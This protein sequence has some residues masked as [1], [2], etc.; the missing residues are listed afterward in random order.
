MSLDIGDVAGVLAGY[1]AGTITYDAAKA[2]LREFGT[3][4]DDID[5]LLAG[6]AAIGVGAAVG[7]L[8][9]DVFDGIFGGD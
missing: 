5:P 4:D 9:D 3:G 1:K 6:V 2:M 8:V 7:S